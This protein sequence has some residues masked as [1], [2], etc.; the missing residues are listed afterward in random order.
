VLDAAAR[1]IQPGVMTDEI[2]RVVHEATIAAGAEFLLCFLLKHFKSY[3]FY[4]Y[5]L[6]SL[7]INEAWILQHSSLLCGIQFL[8]YIYVKPFAI[9]YS[10]SYSTISFTCYNCENDKFTPMDN[11]FTRLLEK[12]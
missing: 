6:V 5:F 10:Y 9:K 1:I 3:I 11:M 4:I 7:S 2:D 12:I 8:I